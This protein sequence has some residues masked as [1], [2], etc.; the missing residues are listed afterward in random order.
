MTATP[1]YAIICART[2]DALAARYGGV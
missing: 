2:G 1:R